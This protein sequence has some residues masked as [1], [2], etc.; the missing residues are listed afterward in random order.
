MLIGE[1]ARQTGVASRTLRFYEDQDLLPPPDRTPAGYRTYPERAADRVRFIKDA[2]AAGF[3]LAEI[4][5]ILTI[6]D[7]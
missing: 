2:Q 4:R 5:E 3:T 6:R 7:G 1:L